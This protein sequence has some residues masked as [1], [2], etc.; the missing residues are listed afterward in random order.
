MQKL[1]P[2]GQPTDGSKVAAS[3]RGFLLD[4]D[5]HVASADPRGKQG[6]PD[7]LVRVLAKI[8]AKP[9]HALALHNPVCINPLVKVGNV[10]DMAANN[11]HGPWLVTPDQLAHA[12]DFKHVGRNAADSHDVISAIANFF[13]EPLLGRKIEQRAWGSDVRL[14]EHQTPRAVEHP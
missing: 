3:A 5:S 1:H 9:S 2:T 11:N 12:F 8:L 4:R 14:N 7:G 13:D 10:G 6:V